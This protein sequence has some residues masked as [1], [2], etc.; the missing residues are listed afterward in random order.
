MSLRVA[1]GQFASTG[2]L[3]ADVET[4]LAAIDQAKGADLLVLPELFLGGYQLPPLIVDADDPLLAQIETAAVAADLVV[5]V[6]ACLASPAGATIST[7]GFGQGVRRRLYDKQNPCGEENDY[8]VPGEHGVLLD[9]RGWSIG[10]AICYDGCFPEHARSLAQA[11]AE[12]YVASVAYLAGSA[13]RREL[14]YRSRALENGMFV[15]VSGMRGELNGLTF[16]GGSAIYDPQGRV[17]AA[18][19]A[20]DE[21]VSWQLDRGVLEQ[22]R[23]EH[24]MLADVRSPAPV[25]QFEVM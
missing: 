18:A 4:V 22:T 10:L 9:L 20:G 5:L 12:V 21:V 3:D 16:D 1:T 19:G 23:R 8:V 14:Y 7:L 13:H 6:G 15:V 2:R 17:L 11:G 25:S 24:P